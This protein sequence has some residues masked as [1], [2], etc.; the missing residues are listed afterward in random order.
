[1]SSKNTE[2]FCNFGK[3]GSVFSFGKSNLKKS[4][5]VTSSAL[6]LSSV[7]ITKLYAGSACNVGTDWSGGTAPIDDSCTVSD[8]TFN[9]QYSDH[10][11]GSALADGAGTTLTLNGDLSVIKH[12]TSGI[13]GVDRLGNLDPSVNGKTKLDIGSR[14]GIIPL[15]DAGGQSYTVNV[16]TN[17]SFTTS[18][19]GN[20]KVLKAQAVGN[21]QYISAGF[22]KASNGAHIDVKFDDFKGNNPYGAPQTT[23]FALKNSNLT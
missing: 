17:T 13:S 11:V 22:G 19:W 12:G 23:Y 18:D 16:Y 14:N 2:N 1:M 3:I 10:Y 5:F 20:A 7:C 15:V 9:P 21:D 8:A 6:L 4:I